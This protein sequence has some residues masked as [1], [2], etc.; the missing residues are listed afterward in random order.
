MSSSV[1]AG[2]PV[3][4]LG[5]DRLHAGEMQHR[6]EQHRG[7][8]VGQHEAVAI[9]PDRI[10]RIEAQEMLPQRVN[11]RRQGHRRAGMAGIRPA[12][13]HPSTRCGSCRCRVGPWTARSPMLFLPHPRQ[14][15][16]AGFASW[17]GRGANLPAGLLPFRCCRERW[18][19]R[20]DLDPPCFLRGADTL[21][22]VMPS[23]EERSFGL[24]SPISTLRPRR[25]THRTGRA[26]NAAEPGRKLA[27]YRLRVGCRCL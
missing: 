22:E 9:G 27:R 1:T 3:A 7:V 5:V 16:R 26:Q 4:R 10:V 23:A 11:H 14:R 15:P 24:E 17:Q 18:P 8:A 2:S 20:R 6:I 25:G 12:A 13:P 21:A 19:L